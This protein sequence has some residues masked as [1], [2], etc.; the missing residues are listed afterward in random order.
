MCTGRLQDT[1]GPFVT[2]LFY[3]FHTGSE[4]DKEYKEKKTVPFLV[5]VS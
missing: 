2:G 5:Q 1:T 4:S 3:L